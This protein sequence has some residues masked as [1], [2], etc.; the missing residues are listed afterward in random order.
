MKKI[1]LLPKVILF[2]FA[3]VLCMA[4]YAQNKK[5]E[6][7]D[8]SSN[9]ISLDSFNVKLEKD[10][11]YVDIRTGNGVTIM[12]LKKYTE[13]PRNPTEEKKFKQSGEFFGQTRKK[14]SNYPR[15]RT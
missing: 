9:Q 7:L 1:T 8:E 2:I 3:M 15:P 11:V 12:Q 6:Y 14:F 13:F 5:Y 10:S 4:S